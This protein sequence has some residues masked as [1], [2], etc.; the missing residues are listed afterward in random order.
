MVQAPEITAKQVEEKRLRGGEEEP[1]L[2]K[3]T[4]QLDANSFMS[5]PMQR[6]LFCRTL[7]N[8][9][10]CAPACLSMCICASAS[11]FGMHC[12]VQDPVRCVRTHLF[13]YCFEM[14]RMESR[15]GKRTPA[16]PKR[17][18]PDPLSSPL[19]E[20]LDRAIP[21]RSVLGSTKEKKRMLNEG[22][23]RRARRGQE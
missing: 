3:T 19:R 11:V 4:T 14:T 16:P 8:S 1:V 2:G 15:A 6:D 13:N 17:S 21:P 7:L 12:S 23:R 20:L 18:V 10:A 22:P 5:Q 9:G